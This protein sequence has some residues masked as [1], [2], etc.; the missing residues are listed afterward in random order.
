MQTK[1]LWLINEIDCEMNTY[2]ETAKV[3][4]LKLAINKEKYR[5]CM[6]AMNAIIKL[7]SALT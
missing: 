1:S 4:F 6:H 5:E 2:N 7:L 3:H